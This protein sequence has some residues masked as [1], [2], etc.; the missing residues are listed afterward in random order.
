M[1]LGSEMYPYM[2]SALLHCWNH[3]F[4]SFWPLCGLKWKGRRDSWGLWSGV[5]HWLINPLTGDSPRLRVIGSYCSFWTWT[6]AH[7]SWAKRDPLII[8]TLKINW[9][10]AEG[11][12][13][14]KSLCKLLKIFHRPH[15]VCSLPFLTLDSLV[16]IK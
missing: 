1:S 10:W 14:E 13:T 16:A 6:A 3:N 7:C 9:F 15:A 2:T 8:A 5:F 11:T 4:R 12:T